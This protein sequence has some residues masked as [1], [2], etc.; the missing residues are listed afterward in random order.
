[1]C[2]RWGLCM[3]LWGP[4][5][6]LACWARC[7]QQALPAVRAPSR[8]SRTHMHCAIA[9]SGRGRQGPVLPRPEPAAMHAVRQT[10]STPGLR[11]SLSNRGCLLNACK[12]SLQLAGSSRPHP[13]RM[14][15]LRWLREP[16]TMWAAG[17]CT[18]ATGSTTLT[19]CWRRWP[20]R[21]AVRPDGHFSHSR[22][23]RVAEAAPPTATAPPCRGNVLP[24]CTLKR[25]AM[26]LVEFQVHRPA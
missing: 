3:P 26:L 6:C 13:R 17:T 23:G 2:P 25:A 7:L 11:A 22:H 5:A 8:V 21:P 15:R 1:M 10:E 4:I 12:G 19:A 20:G 16:C 18:A 24:V 14:C 9:R